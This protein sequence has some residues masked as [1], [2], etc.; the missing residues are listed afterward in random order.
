MIVFISAAPTERQMVGHA[1]RALPA[2]F[3]AVKISG[4]EGLQ[5]DEQID[6]F[7]AEVGTQASLFV[8]RV[9]GGPRYFKRGFARIRQFCQREKRLLMALPG[10]QN[11][12]AEL[13]SIS[14]VPLADAIA[15]QQYALA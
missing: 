5:T 13:E 15:C 8:V 4:S 1:L 6:E 10:D 12:D 3:P 2:G 9:L 14:N 11:P 7:L